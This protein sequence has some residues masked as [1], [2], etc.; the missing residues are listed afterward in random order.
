[1]NIVIVS[2]IDD[3]H[4]RGGSGNAD[5]VLALGDMSDQVIVEVAQAYGCANVFAVKGNHDMP[6][7]F[8]KPIHDLHMKVQE[9]GGLVF[10]GFNGSWKYK[11]R[12]HF[13][14]EQQ[15]AEALLSG[16]PPVDILISHNS[17]RG[18]HDRDDSIHA[19]FD[20]L[21]AYIGRASPR[22]VFH[23]HQHV[24]QETH[25]GNTRVIGVYGHRL[26]EI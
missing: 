16:L 2:D 1:M 13:L 26:I 4:W 21:N 11:P 23:G 15:E 12:G 8:P 9:Y 24:N 25:V 20:A 6:T 10:G 17:P 19:G 18:I 22:F 3:L 5:L 14:Y 7:A